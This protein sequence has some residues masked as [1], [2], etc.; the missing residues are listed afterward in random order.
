MRVTALA[1]SAAAT[2]ALG[3]PASAQ[4]GRAPDRAP[5]E[6]AEA[7][8]FELARLVD[9]EPSDERVRLSELRGRPVALVF[10]S[11]T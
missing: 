3:A 11:Y 9:G 2:L 7:P 10:G 8:D 5:A 1:L 4:R 6:G